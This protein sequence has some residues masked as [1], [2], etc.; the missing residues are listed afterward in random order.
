MYAYAQ[1]EHMYGGSLAI[2]IVEA[3]QGILWSGNSIHF[4]SFAERR[5]SRK[6]DKGKTTNIF[7]TQVSLIVFFLSFVVGSK[8]TKFKPVFCCCQKGIMKK[9]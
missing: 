5:K 1:F 7:L 2:Q 4:T 6:T 9:N 3:I 8:S